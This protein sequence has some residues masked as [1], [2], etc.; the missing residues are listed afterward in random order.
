MAV[1]TVLAVFVMRQALKSSKK[2]DSFTRS[3]DNNT[4]RQG[5]RAWRDRYSNC[6]NSQKQELPPGHTLVEKLL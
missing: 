1:I 5:E 4:W 6:L 2:K 3:P